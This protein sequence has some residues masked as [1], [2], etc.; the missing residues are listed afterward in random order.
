MQTEARQCLLVAFVFWTIFSGM[1]CS[2]PD[3]QKVMFT[4]ELTSP[5]EV[6]KNEQTG[7]VIIR[8]TETKDSGGVAIRQRKSIVLAPEIVKKKSPGFFGSLVN[9][10]IFMGDLLI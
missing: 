3:V 9:L 4:S 8:I 10:V 2:S 7:E 1:G 6:T 5:I